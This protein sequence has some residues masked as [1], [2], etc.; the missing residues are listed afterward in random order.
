MTTPKDDSFLEGLKTLAEKATP[1]PYIHREGVHHHFIEAPDFDGSV[2][3][4]TVAQISTSRLGI[5]ER[6]ARDAAFIAAANPQTILKLISRIGELER[7]QRTPGTVE[8]CAYCGQRENAEHW[9][10]SDGDGMA[11]KDCPH[12]LCPIRATAEGPTP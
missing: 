5:A 11:W 2:Y 1:G 12:R 7:H 10:F 6:R 4:F 8:V 9:E 3:P